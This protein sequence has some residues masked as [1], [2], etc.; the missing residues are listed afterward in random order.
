MG[1]TRTLQSVAFFSTCPVSSRYY[2][3]FLTIVLISHANSKGNIPSNNLPTEYFQKNVSDEFVIEH[4]CNLSSF[5]KS[6][7]HCDHSLDNV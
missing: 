3:I 4:D 7:V 2:C 1:P 5:N 6:A